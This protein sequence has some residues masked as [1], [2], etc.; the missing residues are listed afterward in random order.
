M[1][2]VEEFDKQKTRVFKYITFKKRT[3]NEVRI[4][5]KK[6]IEDE[7]LEDIIEY[8]KEAGYIDDYSYT[9]KQVH[10]YMLLKTM[11]IKEIEYKLYQKGIDRKIIE[12]Y[13]SKNR[14][15]LEEYEKQSIEKIKNKKTTQM[16]D[17]E[18]KTYLYK[19]GYKVEEGE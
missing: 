8:L 5:F 19:K 9:E 16:D 2:T 17:E 18:I 13:I 14:E 11:S 1:Y 4:K 7:M 12:E 3:E 6:E 10:E 15:E